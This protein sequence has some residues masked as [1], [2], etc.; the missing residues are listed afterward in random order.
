MIVVILE[1][2]SRLTWLRHCPEI[3]EFITGQLGGVLLNG[4]HKVG[5]NTSPNVYAALR[6]KDVFSDLKTIA[7]SG[8]NGVKFIFNEYAEKG[9][10]RKS[11][12]FGS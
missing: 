8:L 1:S 3:H 11:S 7:L 4:H 2:I 12:V 5:D 9:Y 6:G 10:V